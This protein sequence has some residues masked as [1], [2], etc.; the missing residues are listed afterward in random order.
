MSISTKERLHNIAATIGAGSIAATVEAALLD[1]EAVAT[2]L[3]CSTRHVRRMADDGRMPEPIRLGALVRWRKD[4]LLDWLA[5]G[6]PPVRA[7]RTHAK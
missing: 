1:V 3:N 4:S 2:L 5:G 7:E 6:C